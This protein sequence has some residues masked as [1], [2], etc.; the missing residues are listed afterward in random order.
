MGSLK[1]ELLKAKVVSKKDVKR[2]DHEDRVRKKEVGREEVE[3]EKE[4]FREEIAAK[5]QDGLGIAH[6]CGISRGEYDWN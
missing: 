5:R 4:K 2:S 1:D 6:S 3:K